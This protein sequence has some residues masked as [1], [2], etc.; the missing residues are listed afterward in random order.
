MGT[1]LEAFYIVWRE[2]ISKIKL[3]PLS[4]FNMKPKITFKH[5]KFEEVQNKT[6]F[7]DIIL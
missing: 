2:E 4:K 1:P 6:L 3:S 5:L 7:F